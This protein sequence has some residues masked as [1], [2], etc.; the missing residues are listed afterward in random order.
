MFQDRN[1]SKSTRFLHELPLFSSRVPRQGPDLEKNIRLA[2]QL[3]STGAGE[4]FI[5]EVS[6]P[7]A[8]WRIKGGYVCMYIYIYIYIYTHI[9]IV[10][11]YIYYI[12]IYIFILFCIYIYYINIYIYIWTGFYRISLNMED[13]YIY[14]YIEIYLKILYIYILINIVI[15]RIIY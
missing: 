10:F 14:I 15:Y 13:V 4:E 7:M 11:I 9:Y 2:E 12:Y 6:F 8:W 5:G 1:P 3:Q